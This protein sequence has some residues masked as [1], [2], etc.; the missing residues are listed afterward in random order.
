M[1]DVYK[2]VKRD[3]YEHTATGRVAVMT[4]VYTVDSKGGIGSVNGYNTVHTW[5]CCE[6]TL[7]DGTEV[8][9]IGDLDLWHDSDGVK[10][11][12]GTIGMTGW[13]RKF[14]VEPRHYVEGQNHIMRQVFDQVTGL[15][16]VDRL[17]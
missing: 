13:T 4:N 3:T 17:G 15:T 7:P 6:I 10:W 11:E 14:K 8:I 9:L 5:M 16:L 1:G 12:S 2:G